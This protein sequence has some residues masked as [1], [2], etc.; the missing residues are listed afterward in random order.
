MR[1]IIFT[2]CMLFISLSVFS[3]DK[4]VKRTTSDGGPNGFDNT[5]YFEDGTHITIDCKGAGY[6]SCP[7]VPSGVSSGVGVVFALNEIAMGKLTG[8]TTI[9][10][11]EGNS[12]R[13]K[14]TSK[15][16]E[17]YDSDIRVHPL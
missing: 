10:D 2:A 16:E 15:T 3:I 4:I 5:S 7:D 17:A 13:V 8:E 11:A 6:S 1:K 9:Q 12:F 14:W